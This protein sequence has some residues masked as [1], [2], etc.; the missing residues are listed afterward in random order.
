MQIIPLTNSELVALVDDEDFERLSEWNWSLFVAGGKL[1]R[2]TY[3]WLTTNPPAGLTKYMHHWIIGRPTGGLVTDHV[4][5]NGLNNTRSN[6][7]H[8]T[9]QQNAW[10]EHARRG[11]SR[12]KGVSFKG[13]NRKRPWA[14]QIRHEG[15]ILL[16]G[17]FAEEEEAA[18]AYDEAA[19][20]LR[21]EFA[22]GNFF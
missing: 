8:I 7:R 21:G 5:G 1:R 16:L 3:G 18:R 12:F 4:D 13:G 14:A 2:N 9:N 20:I 17:C 6:L 19:R 15:K 10:N 22:S 11:R